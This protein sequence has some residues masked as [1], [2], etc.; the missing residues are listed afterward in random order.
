[1]F[2][3]FLI[4]KML[5]S[6]LKGVPEEEQEK[7]IKIVTENPELFQK[8]GVEVQDKMKQGKDQIG[9]MTEVMQKYQDDLKGIL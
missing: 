1:M 6:Q 5:K 7:I 2:K 4:K 8:I 3:N 9:A